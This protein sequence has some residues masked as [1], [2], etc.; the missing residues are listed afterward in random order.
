[1][2][3]FPNNKK[4]SWNSKK[5]QKWETVIQRTASGK[6]RSLTNQLYPNWG[7]EA[8]YPA[9][10]DAEANELLG[11]YAT[12]KGQ[13]EP[14]L[15]LDPEDYQCF[16]IPLLRTSAND[17]QAVIPIGGNVEPAEY[18]D[19]VTVYVNDVKVTDY[20]AQNGVIRFRQAP[21]GKVTADY[22]YYWKVHFSEKSLLVEKVFKNINRCKFKLEVVR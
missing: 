20:S 16:K 12:V 10:T 19:N 1:M 17:Y 11:F 4:F 2:R 3:F 7:I 13:Y 9:L 14:F 21:V 22:R 6:M 8:S 18:I 5:S 15:W